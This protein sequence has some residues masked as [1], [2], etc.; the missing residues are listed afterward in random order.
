MRTKLFL[1][2]LMLST[3]SLSASHP[4]THPN[5]RNNDKVIISGTNTHS[6]H[7]AEPVVEFAIATSTLEVQF[8]APPTQ[9]VVTVTNLMSGIYLTDYSCSG[10]IPLP[11]NA[12]ADFLINIEVEGETVFEGILYASDYVPYLNPWI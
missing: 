12:C 9:Y 1:F 7:L 10:C 8:M 2:F 4:A 6:T 5:G 11:S 3:L